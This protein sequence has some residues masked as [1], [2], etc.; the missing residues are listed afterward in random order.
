MDLTEPIV[1]DSGI[2]D[3]GCSNRSAI[4]RLANWAQDLI[5]NKKIIPRSPF[6][7]WAAERVGS[8]DK[9][10][11][12]IFI[13]ARKGMGKS[14]TALYLAS[15]IAEELALLL[16][17]KPSDY[18]TIENCALLMD[19][20][21][22]TNLL[23]SK[24]KYQ[25]LI[26]D[27]AGV[28]ANNREFLSRGNINFNKIMMTCRTKR[29]IVI[30]TSVLKSHVDLN[31]REMSDV[32]ITI[33]K[34]FHSGGFNICKAKNSDVKELSNNKNLTISR[35]LTFDKD[36][37]I[38]FW[39]SFAPDRELAEEYDLQRD[40]AADLI[41]QESNEE[42]NEK[43]AGKTETKQQELFTKYYDTVEKLFI[44][45]PGIKSR[46][47]LRRC[48]GLTLTYLDKMRARG[49]F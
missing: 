15:R 41:L 3:L 17:G 36:K 4:I 1:L 42:L 20:S 9:Q 11:L 33:Y 24:G 16:G 32:L 22:I 38:D 29:W 25:V 21:K 5:D 40:V 7:K 48:P 2:V 31:I 37:K 45:E 26:I 18:F 10:D 44:E 34:S 14:Y 43:Q 23:S 28:G 46:E 49:G 27:D 8:K 13:S 19:S 35:R 47:V 39:V 6:C 30:F 12:T